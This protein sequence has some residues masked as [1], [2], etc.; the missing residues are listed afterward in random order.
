MLLLNK[1]KVLKYAMFAAPLLVASY[2]VLMHLGVGQPYQ[3]RNALFVGLGY[4]FMGMLIRRFEKVLL[5][6]KFSAPVL[7][8]L[9]VICCVTAVFELN[10][11]EQGIAVPFVSCEILLYVIVLLCLKHPD[12]GKG[13]FAEK[14]GHECSLTVYIMHIAVMMVFVLTNNESFFGKY[15][16]VFI[17]AV[18]ATGAYLYKSIKNAVISTRE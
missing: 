5:D 15:G 13:T 1:L 16:A 18:T 11:Y 10:G 2:V 4:T 3:L 12:F 6:R 9:F 7:W 14:L 8:I 17:F